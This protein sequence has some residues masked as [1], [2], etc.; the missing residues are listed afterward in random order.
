[1]RLCAK[2][3]F[4][5]INNLLKN[6][7]G[8][9]NYILRGMLIIIVFSM[10]LKMAAQQTYQLTLDEV[11]ALAQSDAPD[12]LLAS[13]QWKKNYWTYRSFLADFKP[14]VVLGASSLPNYNRSIEPITQDDGSQ[15]YRQRAFMENYAGLS[16][17]QDFAPTGARVEL[18]S[19]IGRTDQFATEDLAASRNYISNPIQFRIEQPLFKFNLMKWRKKIEPIVYKESEKLYSEQME[20][21]ANQSKEFFFNLL[22]SQLDAEAARQDKINADTLLTLSQG[23]FEVGKIA[24]TDLLQVQLSA[25]QA[26]TRLAEAQLLMQTNTEQLRDFLDLQGDVQFDLVPPYDLPGITINPDEALSYAQQNRSD[27]VA[28][29]RRL[30][31]AQQVVAEAKGGTGLDANLVGSF[32]LNQNSE[33]INN[34]YLDLKDQETFKFGIS[35]PIADWGKSKAQRSVAQANLELEQRKIDQEKENFRRVVVLKAQQF[36]LVRR[37]AE[38]AQRY[39]ES[40]KKRY[41]ITYQRY[42]IGKISITDLNLA[43][44][45]QESA[46][47]GYL[48]A[49]RNFWSAVYELRGLT[50][51]DFVSGKTLML[52]APINE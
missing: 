16:L 32:G 33:N 34:A 36:D 9:I 38:I 30:L 20:S 19:G 47:R 40:A 23:R 43:L 3:F 52:N 27:V 13:T 31:Q 28:F 46:R 10:N 45:E 6:K 12:A 41:E 7:M 18:G 8:K 17:Q 2:I 24:E 39:T 14:Q 51:Y 42:L 50:L 21:V 5:R 1:M 37:N 11:V 44:T 35:V 15:I 22:F 26:E 4:Q 48:Q 49:I 25:M 29:Q